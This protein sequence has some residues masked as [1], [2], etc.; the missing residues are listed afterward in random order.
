MIYKGMFV[1]SSI[2]VV[3]CSRKTEAADGW[4]KSQQKIFPA[5]QP[6]CHKVNMED[7]PF[8]MQFGGWTRT[9]GGELHG[10]GHVVSGPDV[11]PMCFFETAIQHFLEEEQ[12]RERVVR[13]RR[14]PRHQK[15]KST[16]SDSDDSQSSDEEWMA[17]YI[18]DPA[19]PQIQD[20]E[21]EPALAVPPDPVA[22]LPEEEDAEVNQEP[23][24]EESETEEPGAD[25]R[26]D[27][28]VSADEELDSSPEEE[29]V[30]QPAPRR[31]RRTVRPPEFYGEK[32]V[33]THGMWF[34][35]NSDQYSFMDNG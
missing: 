17:Q 34:G 32:N 26:R 6:L 18:A 29:E 5:H 27:Q 30:E 10:P 12:E 19:P 33:Y 4:P 24:E 22:A 3:D 13:K 35:R 21:P 1:N 11:Q 2:C 31:S 25:A 8:R 23:A 16:G 7:K 15:S 20:Q 28:F 14:Q 9:V